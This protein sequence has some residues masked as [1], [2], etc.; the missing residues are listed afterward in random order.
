MVHKGPVILQ[1]FGSQPGLSEKLALA[2]NDT[3]YSVDR[4]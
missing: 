1:E 4:G 3:P 2:A